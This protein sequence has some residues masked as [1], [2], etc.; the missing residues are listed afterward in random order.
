MPRQDNTSLALRCQ[1]AWAANDHTTIDA[2]LSESNFVHYTL[3]PEP[4]R[5][6][7]AL[8]E[9]VD[10]VQR[11]FPDLTIENLWIIAEGDSLS[12]RWTMR[13]THN[14]KQASWAGQN[15]LRI[16]DGRIAEDYGVEDGLGMLRQLDVRTIPGSQDESGSIM[17]ILIFPVRMCRD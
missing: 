12:L 15:M 14:D 4:V 2:I 5:G 9:M 13:G 3:A 10:G 11:T 7:A 8:Q 1:R 16:V 17:T 6:H